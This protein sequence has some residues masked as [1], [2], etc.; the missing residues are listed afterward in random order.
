MSD[1]LDPPQG[2]GAD[3]LAEFIDAARHNTFGT[4]VTHRR[5]YDVLVEINA[6]FRKAQEHLS[7][8]ED[9]LPAMFLLRSHSCF[10]GATRL[11]IS[12]QLA[13][14]YMVLRGA[15]EAALYGHF[16]FR[17]PG[18]RGPIWSGRHDSEEAHRLMRNTF[19]HGAVLRCLKKYRESLAEKIDG[20]YSRTI[21]YGGHPNERGLLQSLELDNTEEQDFKLTLNYLG[22]DSPGYRFCIQTLIESGLATLE[23]FTLVFWERFS[24][25]GL[26]DDVEG[27]W[28]WLESNDLWHST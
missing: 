20:L 1:H 6:L 19:T 21:D 18:S 3:E 24:L 22:G 5:A 7:H 26:R 23:V 16:L 10:L 8:S 15:I 12:G 9:W 25:I 27:V 11:A 4:F 13:E 14:T 17:D 28:K 2:W